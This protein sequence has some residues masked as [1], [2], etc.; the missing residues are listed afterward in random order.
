[1][2]NICDQRLPKDSLNLICI[3]VTWLA[4]WVGK[5]NIILHCDWLTE[6]ARW[7][8]L[9]HLWLP[10]VSHKKNLPESYI[11]NPLLA[12][13]VQSKW[14]F[15]FLSVWTLT[16]SRSI[17]TQKKNLASVQPSWPHT[18]S[19]I[20]EYGSLWY[21]GTSKKSSLQTDLVCHSTDSI[22]QVLRLFIEITIKL[23]KIWHCSVCMWFGT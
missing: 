4:P 23:R 6:Q 14:L 11:T 19:I 10:T 8:Y 5:K 17:N 1:M 7:S 3:F 13:L 20:H 9:V 18:S 22:L 2:E 12:K 21:P 15:F 16:P